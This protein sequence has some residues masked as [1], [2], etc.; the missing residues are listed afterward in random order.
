M[1]NGYK[2]TVCKFS[3]WYPICELTVSYLGL[4]N[5]SRFPGRCILVLKNHAE[6]FSDLDTDLAQAFV[7]EARSAARAIK[8]ATGAPRVNFAILG[9]T[10][11]HIHCH[12]I[13]RGFPGDPIPTRTP[14]EHPTKKSEL[15]IREQE[16]L[17]ARLNELVLKT[18]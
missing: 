5:D 6:S 8:I 7:M 13:P 3:L 12:L 15:P 17:V 2:C 1:K 10:Q 4:Y 9:N 16:R 18:K 11:P 14:W